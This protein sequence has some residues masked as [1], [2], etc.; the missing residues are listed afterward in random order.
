MRTQLELMVERDRLVRELGRRELTDRWARAHL[1]G[2]LAALEWM[3][4][5]NSHPPAPRPSLLTK[6]ESE[7]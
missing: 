5:Q 4:G 2:A 3:R 6:P 1:F 7:P